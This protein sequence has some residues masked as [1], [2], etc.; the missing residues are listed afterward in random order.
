CHR[1]PYLSAIV[2]SRS[3]S[4][5]IEGPSIDRIVGERETASRDLSLS[6][7]ANGGLDPVRS[8]DGVLVLPDPDDRPSRLTEALIRVAVAPHVRV[9]LLAPPL[10]VRL[11]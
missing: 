3:A 8:S 10:A 4:T 11:R 6:L 5:S 9:E 2:E 7:S 1:F